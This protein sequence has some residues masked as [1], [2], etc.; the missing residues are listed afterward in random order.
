M[1]W[2]WI[3]GPAIGAVIGYIT[4]DIAV[5]MMFRPHTEKHLFGRR[6][7]F[8]PG[9]IPK[10]RPR[11]ARA[12]RDVLDQELLSPEVLEAALLS[13]QMLTRIDQAAD[14][15]LQS[16]MREER[17]P[18]A[19]L[20]G[21]FGQASFDD[22]EAR[23]KRMAG[24]FLMEK[25]LESGVEQVLAEAA[26]QEARKRVSSTA[27]GIGR[28]FFDDKRS[29]SLESSL[30]QTI[31]EMLAT[32]GP[33]LIDGVLEN[34]LRDG[35]DT[36]VGDLLARYADKLDDVRAF[37]VAQYQQIIRV[38]LASALRTLDL[39]AIVEDKLNDLNMAELEALIMRVMK[40]ELRAIVWLGALLGS[41]MG[42]AN[43]LVSLLL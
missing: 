12:I 30:T 28:L 11:L 6:V 32:H 29:A 37:L 3:T 13:E 21:L 5:K 41:V 17:T 39:G 10:E 38:G 40:K 18:R 1:N 15:A 35:L 22:F 26:V 7:P 24:I 16:L 23:T 36:P 33:G 19:L 31:R 20:E 34:I 27:A 9:L 42:L 25:L 8:T 2:Q 4:N 43:V 14:G